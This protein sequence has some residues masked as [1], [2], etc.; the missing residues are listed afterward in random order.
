MLVQT[1]LAIEN[2]LF[3]KRRKTSPQ[4][5]R[6]RCSSVR[7]WGLGKDLREERGGCS[8]Q[9]EVL[10][11]SRGEIRIDWEMGRTGVA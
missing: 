11:N 8:R 2:T 9:G 7:N 5:V 10:S 3:V 4:A 1:L 6:V